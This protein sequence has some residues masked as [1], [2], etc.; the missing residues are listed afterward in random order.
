M[1]EMFG[2]CRKDD[3]L[4]PPE[5]LCVGDAVRVVNGPFAGL[6]AEVENVS[7]HSRA[8]LLLDVMGRATRTEFAHTDLEKIPAA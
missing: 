4:R 2:R 7:D 8:A 5:D 3:V 6:L 1:Q